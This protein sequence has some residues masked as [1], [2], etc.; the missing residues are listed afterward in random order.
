[1][2]KELFKKITD[3]RTLWK[4]W[5]K[6]KEKNT[7]SGIDNISIDTFEKNLDVNLKSLRL[8]LENETYIP[9]PLTRIPIPKDSSREKRFIGIPCVKDKVHSGLSPS[10]GPS[11]WF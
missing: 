5:Q 8:E 10:V 3:I 9:E 11:G 7:A 2:K 4:A 6:V 1:L